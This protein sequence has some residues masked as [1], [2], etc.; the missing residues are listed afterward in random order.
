[1]TEKKKTKKGGAKGKSNK[2]KGSAKK[3][4][5]KKVLESMAA[6]SIG[7]CE[8]AAI[9]D[10]EHVKALLTSSLCIVWRLGEFR[11]RVRQAV[12]DWAQEP[13]AS[14][15]PTNT[16]SELAKGP[17]WNTGHMGQL[18]QSVNVNRVF[19]PPFPGTV[20]QP[21]SQLVPGST[22]VLQWEAIVWRHQNPL[23]PCFAFTD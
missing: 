7:I 9:T 23:T 21:P 6:A 2:G 3:D 14:I 12:A 5:A 20:M 13:V 15:S 22:T 18:V 4:S 8:L 11:A 16:L 10:P 1:M 17:P 19:E